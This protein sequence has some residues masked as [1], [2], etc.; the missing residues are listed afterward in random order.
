MNPAPTAA[1]SWFNGAPVFQSAGAAHLVAKIEF[2]TARMNLLCV[3]GGREQHEQRSDEGKFERH[4]KHQNIS[5]HDA[6]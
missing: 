5:S 4:G 1:R 6:I 3:G 2:G